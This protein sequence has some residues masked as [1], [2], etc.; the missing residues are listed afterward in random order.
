MY[1]PRVS[2]RVRFYRE[3][4]VN[5]DT[6]L[7]A[8]QPRVGTST[9]YDPSQDLATQLAAIKTDA[10]KAEE[11]ASICIAFDMNQPFLDTITRDGNSLVAVNGSVYA[12]WDG[13]QQSKLKNTFNFANNVLATASLNPIW[14][15]RFTTAGTTGGGATVNGTYYFDVRWTPDD[16]DPVKRET[17]SAPRFKGTWQPGPA[18]LW[19]Y[20]KYYNK[21]T[22]FKKRIIVTFIPVEMHTAHPN[23]NNDQRPFWDYN[24]AQEPTLNNGVLYSNEWQPGTSRFA[25]GVQKRNQQRYVMGFMGDKIPSGV[26][27]VPFYKKADVPL[28]SAEHEMKYIV[29]NPDARRNAPKAYKLGYSMWQKRQYGA[30]KFT[31]A[32][33][34]WYLNNGSP[35]HYVSQTEPD[36]A[37][38]DLYANFFLSSLDDSMFPGYVPKIAGQLRVQ[39]YT[40]VLFWDRVDFRIIA[41]PPAGD[42]AAT[43][44]V[45]VAPEIGDKEDD[46]VDL[47]LEPPDE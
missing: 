1:K 34:Y 20:F 31:P 9:S 28:R 41:N 21:M 38:K 27:L 25:E 15:S 37:T 44:I 6:S 45:E 10:K 17:P 22:V 43:G 32:D 29:H 12:G 4:H 39:S 11:E 14:Y 18:K 42:A 24:S 3:D 19:E 36:G 13:T 26:G 35:Q 8:F 46:L 30:G 23:A 5:F 16:L 7:S 47:E 33:D 40:D 2:S